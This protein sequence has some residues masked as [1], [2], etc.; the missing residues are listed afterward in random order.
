MKSIVLFCILLLAAASQSI[1][2]MCAMLPPLKG[3]SQLEPYQFIARVVITDDG[4]VPGNYRKDTG[5]LQIK[6]LTLFKGKPVKQLIEHS[7][8]S[9]CDLGISKGQEWVIFA[10]EYGGELHI[11]PCDRNVL[12]R[13]VN[14]ERDW[15]LKR[16]MEVLDK[17]SELYQH[18]APV[19]PDGLH[20]VVYAN[21]QKELTE[22]YHQQ[23]LQG[24]RK[25]WYAN[26]QLR[27]SEHYINGALDGNA[28]WWYPSGQLEEESFYKTGKFYNVSRY[29]YDTTLIPG[30]KA[31]LV[32]MIYDTEA[33]LEQAYKRIQVH[34]ERVFAPDGTLLV[35]REYQRSGQI[36]NEYLMNEKNDPALH[37]TYFDNGRMA[38]LSH[39]TAY[40]PVGRFYEFNQDGTLKRSGVTDEKGNTIWEPA[41]LSTR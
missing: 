40:Q 34:Y 30:M 8:N 27:A 12:Y 35:D 32:P 22:N 28:N 4:D 3:L 31:M 17:L 24:E 26:G 36:K 11:Q 6:I 10:Q 13:S 29:Y 25:L 39:D 9:S 19:Y 23:Q 41:P 33:A 37:I 2:C 21:G 15:R 38:G 20:T 1:A 18:P 14:G 7:K 16:G 5:M